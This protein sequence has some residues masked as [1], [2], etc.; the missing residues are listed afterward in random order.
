MVVAGVP[1]IFEAGPEGSVALAAASP[2]VRHSSTSRRVCLVASE[3]GNIIAATVG[4]NV[5]NHE[6]LRDP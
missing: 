4:G 2:A 1:C 3:V 6:I 5:F